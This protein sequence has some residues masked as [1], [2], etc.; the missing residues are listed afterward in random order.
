MTKPEMLVPVL[1]GPLEDWLPLFPDAPFGAAFVLAAPL[2]VM[3]TCLEVDAF[4]GNT[5]ITPEAA[6]LDDEAEPSATGNALVKP[7]EAWVENGD[8]SLVAAWPGVREAVQAKRIE[9]KHT[10][11]KRSE[12]G[13]DFLLSA[14]G[15]AKATGQYTHSYMN[16]RR[17]A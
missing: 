1:R 6:E 9:P 4:G 17:Y 7:G 2:R 15:T 14:I 12:G 3:K 13:M 10:A 16:A 8:G 11:I 5:R